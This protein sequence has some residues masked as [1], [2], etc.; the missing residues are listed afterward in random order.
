MKVFLRVK[1]GSWQLTVE[2]GED[3]AAWGAVMLALGQ[4]WCPVLLSVTA[5]HWNATTTQAEWSILCLLLLVMTAEP[6]PHLSVVSRQST[7]RHTLK[8][9]VSLPSSS[10]CFCCCSFSIFFQQNFIQVNF[11]G[12]FLFYKIFIG[13]L[14]SARIVMLENDMNCLT[15]DKL[16]FVLV[17]CSFDCDNF[18][19]ISVTWSVV[20]V[21]MHSLLYFHVLEENYVVPK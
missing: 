12:E 6:P 14:C 13:I 9:W 18:I 19:T 21:S 5:T 7:H 10:A 3:G 20:I 17:A 15:N 2:S 11:E 4:A 8:R 1:I 16:Y